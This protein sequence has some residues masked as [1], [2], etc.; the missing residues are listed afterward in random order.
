MLTLFPSTVRVI[1]SVYSSAGSR[2]SQVMPEIS[3]LPT[4]PLPQSR[5]SVVVSVIKGVGVTTILPLIARFSSVAPLSRVPQRRPKDAVVESEPCSIL[6]V[7]F[8]ILR[9]LI[10]AASVIVPNRPAF[11]FFA[12]FWIT[13]M[14]LKVWPL[15]LMVPVNSP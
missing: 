13:V 10:D 15:P 14:L 5:P 12:S 6:K 1:G 4:V 2:A 11:P 9:L 7:T 8:S 3:M